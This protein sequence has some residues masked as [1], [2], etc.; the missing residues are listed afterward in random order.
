MYAY[1]FTYIYRERGAERGGTSA[2]AGG[3]DVLAELGLLPVYIMIYIYIYIYMY[4]YKYI[5]IC[6]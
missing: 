5:Y 6:I 2:D 1:I 4:I 3:L